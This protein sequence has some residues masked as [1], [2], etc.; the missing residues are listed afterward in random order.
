MTCL[1]L[2]T[3]MFSVP[4]VLQPENP[5]FTAIL[6]TGKGLSNEKDSVHEDP[7]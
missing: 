4:S 3:Q 5:A 7:T 2:N 6:C 1:W